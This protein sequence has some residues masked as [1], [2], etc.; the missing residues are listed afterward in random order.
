MTMS[1]YGLT[2]RCIGKARAT[3]NIALLNLTYNMYHYESLCRVKD[4]GVVS[5]ANF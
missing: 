1:F 3:L 4:R 5:V 2:L